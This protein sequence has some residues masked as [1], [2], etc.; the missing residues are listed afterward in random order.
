[1]HSKQTKKEP[2]SASVQLIRALGF[3][4]GSGIVMLF[5]TL[6]LAAVSVQHSSLEGRRVF[7]FAIV[8]AAV[9]SLTAGFTSAKIMRCKGILHGAL[10]S[11]ILA[12]LL[13]FISLLCS[14]FKFTYRSIVIL[15]TMILAGA[16]GG[17]TAVNF[18]R[19]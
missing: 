17:I 7:I 18:I 4:I 11:L 12:F 3:G 2:I 6:S 9:S 14:D 16:T 10:S 15:L 8:C 13:I 19:R 5:I 1:M